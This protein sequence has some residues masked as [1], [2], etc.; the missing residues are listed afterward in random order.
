VRGVHQEP[1]RRSARGS[2]ARAA[3]TADGISPVT[4]RQRRDKNIKGGSV[5]SG[6]RLEKD[7]AQALCETAK[8]DAKGNVAELARFYIR[9]GL[10]ASTAEANAREEAGDFI[11]SGLAGLWMDK[12]TVDRL[13]AHRKRTGASRAAV[14]R[15]LIRLGLNY[16][17]EDSQKREAG[18]A[19]LADA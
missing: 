7:V 8:R 12:Y 2:G 9:T 19:A 17:P 13:N 6:L 1:A 14:A 5:I 3:C 11:S 18:F 16:S 4:I 15:H 10:G